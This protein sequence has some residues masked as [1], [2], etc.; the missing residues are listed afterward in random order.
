MKYHV[1]EN[2]SYV[3]ISFTKWQFCQLVTDNHWLGKASN[4]VYKIGK[5][6]NYTVKTTYN[7]RSGNIEWSLMQR[8]ENLTLYSLISHWRRLL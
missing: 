5:G 8:T 3:G 2:N 4:V 1:T 7:G 6:Q